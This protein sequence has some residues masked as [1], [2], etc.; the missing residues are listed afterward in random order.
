VV[1]CFLGADGWLICWDIRIC[2]ICACFLVVLI[3][4]MNDFFVFVM[5]I[6]LLNYVDKD[7]K[8]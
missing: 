2:L 5:Q 1:F 3:L 7:R 8:T 4:N 6:F